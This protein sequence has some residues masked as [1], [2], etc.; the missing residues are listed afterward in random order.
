MSDMLETL[1]K[2]VKAPTLEKADTN[3]RY[4]KAARMKDWSKKIE[5]IDIE[6]VESLE[7]SMK[8]YVDKFVLGD[9][10]EME[11]ARKLSQEEIDTMAE[12]YIAMDEMMTYLEARKKQFRSMVF[13][14]LNVRYA[15]EEE[16]SKSQS[17]HLAEYRPGKLPSEK[18]GKT[19]NREGGTRKDPKI[20]WEKLEKALGDRFSIVTEKVTIPAVEEQVVQRPSEELLLEAVNRGDVTLEEVREALEEGGYNSPKFVVRN[21]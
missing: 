6:K 21:L 4:S 10:V 2:L 9:R 5:S 8:S 11:E 15:E 16:S 12:E 14:S 7:K 20:N 19:F 18:F 13:T 3:T 1:V 17:T